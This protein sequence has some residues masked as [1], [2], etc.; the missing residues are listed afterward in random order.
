MITFDQVNAVAGL[1]GPNEIETVIKINESV[2]NQIAGK[3][4][5]ISAQLVNDPDHIAQDAT[6]GEPANMQIADLG[7]C[8]SVKI[9]RQ[10]HDRQNE[11]AN[12]KL[13]ELAHGNRGQTKVEERRRRREGASEKLP[14]I[15][16]SARSRITQASG[17]PDE[18]EQGEDR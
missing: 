4:N 8:Q 17:V 14:P 18:S 12:A 2:V 3:E 13:I 11:T 1:H 6:R 10:I 15:Q 9:G 7:N 5:E 16:C